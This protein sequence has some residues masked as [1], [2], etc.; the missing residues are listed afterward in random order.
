MKKL[1]IME[2]GEARN[3]VRSN[4][5]C[6]LEAKRFSQKDLAAMIGISQPRLSRLIRHQ[7][8]ATCD[9]AD[10]IGVSVATI[11]RLEGTRKCLGLKAKRNFKDDTLKKIRGLSRYGYYLWRR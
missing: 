9:T 5:L 10:A 11:N 1:K 8:T 7:E 2:I 4:V 6:E 3:F